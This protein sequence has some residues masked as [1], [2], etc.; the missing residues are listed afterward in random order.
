MSRSPER[1]WWRDAVVYQVYI[2][3]F[4]DGNSDGTGDLAGLRSRLP[5]LRDLG[6]DAVWVNPWYVSPLRDGGYDVAD[7]RDIDPRFGSLD[8][9][10][11][12]IAEAREFG[13]R[14]ILDL[15]PNHTSSEH[16]WFQEALSAPPGSDAR[17][18]YHFAAAPNDWRSVFGGTAWTR[19]P[20]G[21]WYLHLFDPSQPD[22]NWNNPEV[23]DEFV[24]I[25]RFWLDRGAAG[26][27]VDVAHGLAKDPRYP[28]LSESSH[29]ESWEIAPR[30]DSHPFWDRPEV[31]DVIRQ[32][33]SVVDDYPGA[34]MVAEAWVANWERLAR[35]VRPDEYHQTFD[36]LFVL[37]PWDAAQMRSAI[38]SAV[39]GAA[40]V[41]AV[42]TWTLSNHDVVRHATRYGLPQDVDARAWLLDGDRAALDRELGTRRARA[43]ALM[44]LALPG[45]VYLYQGEE[46][47]LF[48]VDDL[49]V[50]VL[51]DPIWVRSRGRVKGRDGCRVPIPWKRDGASM[52]FGGGGAWMPQP[53]P[54]RGMSVEAQRG[55]DGSMLEL[56]RAALAIRRRSR[57]EDELHWLDI[58]DDVLGFRCG[59]LTCVV[60]FGAAPV[61]LP[62]GEMVLAS[63]GV[64]GGMLESDCAVWSFHWPGAD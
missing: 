22:L 32:W 50:E 41:G 20:D 29:P 42:P 16:A 38:A 14:M 6:V 55:A 34:M 28:P 11:E 52:G 19:A 13:V 17:S 7:Y 60:N 5:Y 58:A 59:E 26:F 24:S 37:T 40:S 63:G 33:R 9:A 12:L 62:A 18:R 35:Y 31:H 27:R 39:E 2:R 46:L 51:D 44:M 10:T 15:V 8:E 48:E 25:L 47:G 23:R 3:S 1:P 30:D 4:A 54:W 49:P 21:Q 57:R 43:A 36:F 61:K 56:Y 45:S 53:E 64:E